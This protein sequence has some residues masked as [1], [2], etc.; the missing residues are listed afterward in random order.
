MDKIP[1]VSDLVKKTEYDATISD[2]ETIYP[3]TSDYNKFMGQILNKYIK[4]KE[5]LVNLIFLDLQI[6]LT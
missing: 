6:T 5:Q 4:E 3:I 2:N 1:K